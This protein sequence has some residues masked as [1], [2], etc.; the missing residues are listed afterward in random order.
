VSAR[1]IDRIAALG[2]GV[3]IQHRMAFQGE[4]FIERYGRDAAR[5]TP[6]VRLLL[7]SGVPLG[8]GT[9]ATRVASYNPWVGLYWLVSGRTIGGAALYDASERLSR[10]EALALYTSR[11]AW[12]S[13]EDGQKGKIEAGQLADFAVLNQDYFTVAE[14]RIRDTESLLT[15][16]GGKVVWAAGDFGPLAPPALPFSPG[17]SPPAADLNSPPRETARSVLPWTGGSC[18]V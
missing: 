11:N 6:P 5:H 2:G 8:G 15:V 9:D 3:A 16:L 18:F 7:E 10:N 12:F 13:G 4:Y 17:W 14:D 1:N